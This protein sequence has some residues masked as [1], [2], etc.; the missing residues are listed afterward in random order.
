M[1]STLS[2][3]LSALPFKFLDLSLNFISSLFASTSVFN[4]RS[5]FAVSSSSSSSSSMTSP[6]QL[7]S[8]DIHLDETLVLW[9]SNIRDTLRGAAADSVW[10]GDEQ[11]DV[12]VDVDSLDV[13]SSLD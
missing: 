3:K 12:F 7:L 2:Y 6:A 5:S 9:S 4:T 10:R 1:T 13:S 11:E 8:R